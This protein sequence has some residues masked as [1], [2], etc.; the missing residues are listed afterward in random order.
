MAQSSGDAMAGVDNLTPWQKGQSGNPKGKKK[1][2][3]NY[4]TRLREMLDL[5]ATS[6]DYDNDDAAM[7]ERLSSLMG[8]RK[9][10]K[11]DVMLIKLVVQATKK[12]NLQAM[13]QIMDRLEGKAV[14]KNVNENIERTYEDYLES[15]P[16]ED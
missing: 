3:K 1:G 5:V 6:D 9:I 14:Q 2:T 15:L 8:D 12:N 13:T 4:T 16:D 10:T 7:I 11:G